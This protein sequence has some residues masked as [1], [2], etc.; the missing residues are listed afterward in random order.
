MARAFTVPGRFN[1]P[2]DSGNG[3]YVG[4]LLAQ[5]L[6]GPAVVNLRSRVPLD[7]PLWVR[8]G[9]GGLRLLDGETLV[10][11]AEPA[12]ALPAEVPE[13]VGLERAR[14]A[15]AAYRGPEDG[16][17]SRC[18]VCGRGR[19]DALGVFAGELGDGLVASPWTPPP[20]AAGEDGAVRPE[21]VW[22]VLDCPTYFATYSG[23]ELAVCFLVRHSVTVHAPVRA[24]EEHVVLAWPLAVEGRKRSA[25]AAILSAAGEVLASG[26]ALMVEP[27]P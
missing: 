15:A 17:F 10:A 2:A 14:E 11:E 26:R 6:G 16:L 27:R 19:E 22:A 8:E 9:E 18:F 20:W 5:R 12:A 3:G 24:G 25:G 21:L 23:R 7:V 13:R 1:G 4:G